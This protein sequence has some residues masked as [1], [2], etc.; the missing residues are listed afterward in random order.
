MF[1]VICY[2][3]SLVILY[4]T[5]LDTQLRNEATTFLFTTTSSFEPLRF[6]HCQEQEQ[7]QSRCPQN[8]HQSINSV[9]KHLASCTQVK[10]A[11]KSNFHVFVYLFYIFLYIEFIYSTGSYYILFVYKT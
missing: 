11:L 6:P 4:L 7:T 1:S 9:Q 5:S 8:V 2:K 3:F 10:D